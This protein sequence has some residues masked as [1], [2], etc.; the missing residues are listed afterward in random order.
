MNQVQNQSNR[1]RIQA[2]V[3][4]VLIAKEIILMNVNSKKPRLGTTVLCRASNQ[5]KKTH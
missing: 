3:K 5:E 4:L 2:I 1:S